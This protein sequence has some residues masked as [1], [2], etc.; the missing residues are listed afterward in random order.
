M[1]NWAGCYSREMCPNSKAFEVPGRGKSNEAT[2][3]DKVPYTATP[4]TM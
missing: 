1:G 4:R 2:R 3:A